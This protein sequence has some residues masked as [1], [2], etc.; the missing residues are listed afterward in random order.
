M[1]IEQFIPWEDEMDEF[2]FPSHTSVMSRELLIEELEKQGIK[3]NKP[4]SVK[5][6]VKTDS[7]APQVDDSM[8]LRK[9]VIK[10]KK[11]FRS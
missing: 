10:S 11:N 6:S 5:S 7:A 2:V 9:K 4:K 3:E 1:Q 8:M